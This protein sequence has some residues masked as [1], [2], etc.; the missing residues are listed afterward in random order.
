MGFLSGAIL[1]GSAALTCA[2]VKDN[3]YQVIV[4]RNAF[5]LK[6]P[7]PPAPTTPPEPPPSPVEVLLTGISTLSGQ[8]KVLLQVTDK[9]PGKGGKTEYFPPLPEGDK[10]GRIE[11]VRIDAEKGLAVIKID[12]NEKTLTFEKDS[13]KP[14]GGAP[15]PGASAAPTPPGIPVPRP[16][17]IPPTPAAAATTLGGS[18]GGGVLVGGNTAS[19]PAPVAPTPGAVVTPTTAGASTFTSSSG[20][21]PRTLRTGNDAAGGVL[22]GGAGTSTTTTTPATTSAGTTM[23]PEQIRQ[24]LIQQHQMR[25]EAE[26]LG[27]IQPGKLPPLPPPPGG[28]PVT[29][30]TTQPR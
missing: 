16:A 27:L 29:P 20:F 26:S 3:P 25:K 24:H 18:G 30:P 4:T 17:G 5:A 10:Q 14:S 7:P 21:P 13:P 9:G 23:T 15:A 11:V 12:E 28:M 8:P 22:I 6:P 1:A 2:D 19:I